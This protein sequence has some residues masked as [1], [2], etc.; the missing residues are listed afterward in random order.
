MFGSPF[1]KSEIQ[2]LWPPFEVVQLTLSWPPGPTIFVPAVTVYTPDGDGD[3]GA[4]V[5]G[6]GVGAAGELAPQPRV[7]PRSAA[8][9]PW[10]SI[11]QTTPFRSLFNIDVLSC[12][13]VA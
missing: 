3:T 12:L 1:L 9:L 6:V 8:R 2:S 7:I 5:T 13:K 11:D 4:G 10:A